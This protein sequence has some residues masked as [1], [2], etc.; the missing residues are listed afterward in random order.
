MASKKNNQPT[1]IQYVQHLHTF[2]HYP[3]LPIAG[4]GD[5]PSS[6]L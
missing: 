6:S 1:I 4:E 3:I 5:D 2:V